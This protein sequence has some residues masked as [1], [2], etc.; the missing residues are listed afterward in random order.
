MKQWQKS[1]EAQPNQLEAS[2]NWMQMLLADT[3]LSPQLANKLV[4]VVEEVVTNIINH[5]YK[6][7]AGPLLLKVELDG[8]MIRF[9]IQDEGKQFDPTLY[10]KNNKPL[11][12]R[13]QEGGVGLLLINQI[14]DS[15]AYFRKGDIN[16][17]VLEKAI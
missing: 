16:C 17:L 13:E 11:S 1:F 8:Q 9:F 2:I 4:L 12:P 5:T 6:G 14:M 7:D 15:V 3:Q 10:M